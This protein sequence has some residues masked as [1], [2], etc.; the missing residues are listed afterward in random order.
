[1]GC[2]HDDCIYHDPKWCIHIDNGKGVSLYDRPCRDYEKSP[3]RQ[4]VEAWANGFEVGVKV[5]LERRGSVPV[6]LLQER[7]KMK[8]TPATE[9]T[10]DKKCESIIA[11]QWGH[12]DGGGIETPS[13][14]NAL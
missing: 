9:L 2:L 3:T 10:S 6:G 5:A 13:K 8:H 14:T 11:Y 4:E 12:C 7:E 1:M